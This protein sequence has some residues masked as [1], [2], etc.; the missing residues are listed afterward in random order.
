MSPRAALRPCRQP[1]CPALVEYGACDQH[2]QRRPDNRPSA[3]KR[4]YGHKWRQL[5]AKVLRLEPNCR[6]CRMEGRLVPAQEV[7]HVV[8]LAH[9]G[10]NEL[11]NLAPICGQH[12]RSKTARQSSGWGDA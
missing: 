6:V 5:R 8:P 2:R 10:T 3:S 7:D 12:H 9:G 11:A 1:G 4:G